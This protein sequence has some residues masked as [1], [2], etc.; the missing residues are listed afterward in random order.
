MR[1]VLAE[2]QMLQGMR[3]VISGAVFQL[4]G[5]LNVMNAA[6]QMALRK[7]GT[8]EQTSLPVAEMLEAG[9]AAVE[10]LKSA[11]PR[12]AP[13]PVEP[14]NINELIH[15]VLDIS[16]EDLLRAGVFVDWRPEKQ[17]PNVP[18]RANALRSLIKHLLDN[19]ILAIKDGGG[20]RE[21]V[22]TSSVTPSGDVRLDVRDTGPGLD[23]KLRLKIF[24]PFFTGW[25]KTRFRSGMGLALARRIII[26]QGGSLEIANHMTGG[27]R[28]EVVF[29]AASLGHGQ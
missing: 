17:L 21:I 25:V 20:L 10:R 12:L 19:A 26:E 2:Q 9:Y 23:E 29:A 6:Q 4:Q 28:V 3:E 7:T 8:D 5:P 11:M 27:C 13:E 15:D 16:I 1:A 24:E 22:I 14:V 18:G